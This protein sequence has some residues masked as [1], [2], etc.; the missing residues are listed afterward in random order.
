M[1][2][3]ILLSACIATALMLGSCSKHYL[4]VYPQSELSSGTFW[5]DSSDATQF[6]TGVY[7][8]WANTHPYQVYFSDDW[9]D[10]AIPTGFWHGFYYYIWGIGD[11]S[12][13]NADLDT[14]WSDLYTV[15]RSTNVYLANQ[16]SCVMSQSL[17][18]TLKGEVSFIRAYEY[19]LLYY[20]WGEV[21]MV[22]TPL[23]IGS[24]DVPRAAQGGTV[25]LILQDL[26]TAIAD[27]P[28]MAA[29]AGQVTLGA[30]LALKARVLLYQG[31]YA[32]AAAA[33]QAVMNLGVYQLLRTPAGDGYYQLCNT[34]QVNNQEE[35]L[36]WQNDG[37]TRNN[38]MVQFMNPVT[39]TLVSPTNA[40]V[41]AYEGYNRATDQ[42]VPVDT[43]TATSR[44]LN[45]DPRLDWTIAHTGSVL[46]GDTLNSAS[47][48]LSNQSTGY[49][50]AKYITNEV[51]ANAPNFTTDNILIRYAEVELIYAEAQ[52]EAG[53][54]DQ[55]V[56][57]AIND[58]RSRAYGTVTSD[59]AH[60]PEIT[61][62]NQ[63][64]L[65]A[66]VRNERRVELAFEGLR[67]FDIKRWQIAAGAGG[68][69]NGPVTG[70]Y[71]GNG[72]YLNAGTRALSDPNR[73][74]LRP[75]PQN[76][77]NYEGVSVLTQNPGY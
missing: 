33:A 75:I 56:L 14:Y 45:R 70:A 37:L 36:G 16:G 60:Y 63:D 2:N 67:W 65:R 66:V 52:I 72:V 9:S 61:T 8:T 47:A 53:Q 54:T 23:N 15:I 12:P 25:N 3:S 26:D 38:D 41:S 5:R 20:T 69:M 31:Q 7:S 1:K 28:V 11:I 30:A 74:Y 49:G 57:S 68:T 19:H 48:P 51:I 27:L 42:S 10:D 29:Q 4:D 62:T 40:L 22:T 46:L 77:I 39:N 59:Y 71:I 50:V 44:F 35:I 73:D 76:E 58:V 55:T 17:R 24:L 6:V 13:Q 32:Q 21:P 43:G 18:Q 34:K 64:S